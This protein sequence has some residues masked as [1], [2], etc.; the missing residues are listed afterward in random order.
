MPNTNEQPVGFDFRYGETDLL[1]GSL[2]RSAGRLTIGL[3]IVLTVIALGAGG[4]LLSSILNTSNSSPD[5]IP[6]QLSTN[7]PRPTLNVATVTI[8]PPTRTATFTPTV[9]FTPSITP[10]RS[11]CSYTVPPGGSLFLALTNCGHQSTDV[12]P[13]VLALNGLTDSNSVQANQQILVPWPTPTDDPNALPTDLPTIEGEASANDEGIQIV[14]ASIRAFAA[15]PTPTLPA[16]V[17]WHRVAPQENIITIVNQY[18]ADVKTLSELNREID[19]ARCDFGMTFG[20]P[21]CIVQLFQGQLVRVPAPTPMPTLSPTPD[22]NATATPTPTATVN[23]PNIVSP[24]DRSFF[25]SQDLITLRWVPSATLGPNESY[26]ID[27]ED[28]TNGE[29]YS[30][31]TT[32][33][34]FIMPLDWQ[35]DDAQRHEFVWQVGIVSTENPTNIRFQTEPSTFVWQGSLTPTEGATQ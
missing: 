9:T 24:A 15:T 27:V 30:A 20:G 10:T 4:F 23:V 26:H 12:I 32:E 22:P 7:T 16:G 14:D 8:G 13:T 25:Y 28:R 33:L 5:S 31:L 17:Q 18:N 3:V 21:E 34:T 35:G 29:S 11:P 2:N 1:E 6:V 19:F